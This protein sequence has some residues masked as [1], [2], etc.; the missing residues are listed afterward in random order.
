ML[1]SIL[2]TNIH[3]NSTTA[4]SPQLWGHLLRIK[5]MFNLLKIQL[6]TSVQNRTHLTYLNFEVSTSAQNCAH[7]YSAQN[8][9]QQNYGVNITQPKTWLSTSP[10]DSV[11]LRHENSNTYL[12]YSM[13]ASCAK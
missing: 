2:Q 13:L 6:I 11:K 9:A 10:F 8:C 1:G 12:Q 4:I 7:L 3:T 5:P